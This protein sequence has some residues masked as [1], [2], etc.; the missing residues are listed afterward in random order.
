MA[1]FTRATLVFSLSTICGCQLIGVD[2][3]MDRLDVDD[4][5]V[6]YSGDC[7]DRDPAVTSESD[8]CGDADG[9]GFGDE[10]RLVSACH[11]PPGFVSDCSDC[12]DADAA[13]HPDA[14]ESCNELDDDCDGQ[15]DDLEDDDAPAWYRDEDGDGW[16]GQYYEVLRCSPPDSYV[17]NDD[18]CDD[19]D[20]TV[21]PEADELC[22]EVDDDCDGV[23]DDAPVDGD[24]W[25][26]DAD[27]DGWGDSEQSV[28]ECEQ[29]SGWVEKDG[30][31]D[32]GRED[33]F[34]SATE[35]CGDD[36]DQDCDGELDDCALNGESSLADAA[37]SL[38][39][40][41]TLS[42]LGTVVAGPGD[43]DGDGVDDLVVTALGLSGASLG[44]VLVLGP[45][46][47]GSWSHEDALASLSGSMA[48]DRLG[49]AAAAVGDHDGDG[50]PELLVGAPGAGGAAG[51]MAWLVTSPHDSSRLLGD[52]EN[53]VSSELPNFE[54]GAA[55]AGGGDVDGDGVSDVLI[56][57]PGFPGDG[58]ALGRVYLFLGPFAGR[59][60]LGEADWAATGVEVNSGAGSSLLLGSDFDGDGLSDPAVAAP[61]TGVVFV[62]LGGGLASGSL[63]DLDCVILGDGS[64]S[65]GAALAAG[66][67]DGDGTADLLV[68]APGSAAGV[69]YVFTGLSAGELAVSD[70]SASLEGE[71]DGDK[72]GSAVAVVNDLYGDGTDELLVGAPAADEERGAAY[73]VLGGS[74]GSQSLVDAELILRGE[75]AGDRAGNA[76][77]SAGDPDH[78]GL[79]DLLVGADQLGSGATGLT[80]LVPAAGLGEGGA[81]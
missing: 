56:G 24:T 26:Q 18:D 5:G 47:G 22:N 58:S 38:E 50:L 78:D 29:S 33:V 21:H 55:V 69:V 11:Q 19:A 60:T 3:L 23:V 32:D 2:Q 64:G 79:T 70:A 30:D 31:C 76:V 6:P 1:T 10:E 53:V 49:Q 75:S 66:D 44:T 54:L 7:D 81:R 39:T 59:H 65:L 34:P 42:A 37:W 16:G 67:T 14:E 17:D 57:A 72:A 51:G 41:P 9:D 20:A 28:V 46:L 13:I 77:A 71:D 80:Y 25:Y 43:L 63:E 36:E 15:V 35:L 62:A 4:D 8:W 74:S 52:A 48:D 68:G 61:G 45:P 73:L 40:D 27:G 12:D